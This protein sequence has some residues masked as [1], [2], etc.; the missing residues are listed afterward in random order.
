MESTIRPSEGPLLRAAS[1]LLASSLAFWRVGS[2]RGASRA[3][4]VLFAILTC[5]VGAYVLSVIARGGN[6]DSTFL[7]GWVVAAFEA[8]VGLLCISRALVVSRNK[9]VCV[10]LGLGLV[11]WSLG[12]FLTTLLSNPAAAATPVP[13]DWSYLA[14]Y[15][16]AY[17]AIVLLMR[18]EV[19]RL[20]A[21]SWLD[22]T[23]AGL[24]AAAVCAAFVF[25][26]VLRSSGEPAFA[27]AMN[28]AYSIGD[29]LLFALVVGITALLSGAKRTPWV[30]IA[31]ACGVNA[32]GD[33]LNLFHTSVGASAVGQTA[34]AV[35]WPIAILL[36]TMAMWIRPD[37]PP[38]ALSSEQTGF[39]LPGAAAGA[40]LVILTLGTVETMSRVATA[41]ATA[42]LVVVGVRLVLSVGTLRTLHEL[43]HRQSMTDELTGLGNRRFLTHLV[44]THRSTAEQTTAVPIACLFVDLNRFKEV[45]DLFGHAAGDE[46]LRQIGPRLTASLRRTDLLVRL[47]GDEFAAVLPDTDVAHSIDI[48]TRLAAA[49]RKPF[50]LEDLPIEISASIGIAVAPQHATDLADLLRCADIAMYRAKVSGSPFEVYDSSLD[51]SGDVLRL[52]EDLR[53]ALQ[54]KEE[55]TLHFQPQLDLKTGRI[56]A[57]E[58]LVRWMHPRIGMIPPLKFIS[59]AEEAGLMPALT[60]LVLN[61]A[62]AQCAK[63]RGEGREITV[64]VNVSASNLLDDGFADLVTSTLRRHDVP[65]QAL[66]LEIT[67]TCMITDYDRSRRV[68]EHLRDIGVTTSIDDFGA[69]FTALAYLGDLAVGELKLDRSFVADLATRER[70]R[71]L[72][73]V[74]STIGL[75]HALG[76]RVVAEGIEDRETLQLLGEFGC[77]V[78]QGYVVSK[79]AEP[80]AL[81]LDG[82][83]VLVD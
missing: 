4:R 10:V 24:G 61:D 71:D 50:P 53:S 48:A 40:A 9:A 82:P 13:A 46:L 77:D 74:R 11:A 58:A 5:F 32:V 39:V 3:V 47:G 59:L 68:I 51:D 16:L 60:E 33:T 27:T 30:M 80:D 12:D 17:G 36:M 52:V 66:V 78:V 28:L 1:W 83:L 34:N 6:A 25:H 29:V 43:R 15:P 67:E 44:D 81:E 22:G 37:Q 20:P 7:D 38:V 18:A 26:T 31:V 69:G 75:G 57:A 42:S 70:R 8:T 63:W 21:P 73:L 23:I 64:S 56:A 79:P 62:V 14:F 49:L 76:L 54:R 19:S 72:E 45:N 35:A 65:P 2:E 55:L 41:L